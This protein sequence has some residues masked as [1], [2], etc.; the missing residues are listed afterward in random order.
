MTDIKKITIIS[1]PEENGDI[2]LEM[3][4]QILVEGERL[5]VNKIE[6]VSELR[7]GTRVTVEFTSNPWL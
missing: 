7:F 1:V 4:K 5:T 2:V 6:R 3:G